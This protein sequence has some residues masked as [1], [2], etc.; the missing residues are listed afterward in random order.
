VM[1]YLLAIFTVLLSSSGQIF[2]KKA[3]LYANVDNVRKSRYFLMS[4]YALF[5]LAVVVSY[6]LMGLIPM[7]YFTV[8]MSSNY[9]FVMIA[10]SFFLNEQLTKHKVFGT[11][12]VV[13]G[14]V[15]FLL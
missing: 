13:T 6:V 10:S 12:I 8:I 5:V 1:M 3:A 9:V 2:L 4:G 15:I 11:L 14:M 7:K